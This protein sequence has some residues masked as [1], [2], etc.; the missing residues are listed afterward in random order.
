MNRRKSTE[1]N[2]F[3]DLEPGLD[4]SLSVEEI[5]GNRAEPIEAIG[6]DE[7][8]KGSSESRKRKRRAEP[9]N[10]EETL[11]VSETKRAEQ[12]DQRLKLDR[13]R[14]EFEQS[15]AEKLDVREDKRLELMSNQN[16][17]QQQQQRD[18]AMMQMKM[19]SVMEEVLKKFGR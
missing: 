10:L 17:L 15:R 8:N 2:E 16:D 4:D 3:G 13:D 7:V 12:E 19:M 6:S 5:I 11:R 18:N 14:L 1:R 9:I